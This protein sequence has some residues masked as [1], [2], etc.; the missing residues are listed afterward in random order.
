MTVKRKRL[1]PRGFITD[2]TSRVE[3]AGHTAIYI[4]IDGEG[5]PRYVGQSCRPRE[6]LTDHLRCTSCSLSA[7]WIAE[8]VRSR[9]PLHMEIVQWTNN[10]EHVEQSWIASLRQAGLELLN[11]TTGGKCAWRSSHP[12]IHQARRFAARVRDR[13][14]DLLEVIND[15]VRE[16]TIAGPLAL[17]TLDRDMGHIL[18]KRRMGSTWR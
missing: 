4:L 16:A 6:R 12:A 1:H 14:P 3:R 18:S 15:R 11:M 8:M 9:T 5:C 10:P 7:S 17:M 13:F 2:S